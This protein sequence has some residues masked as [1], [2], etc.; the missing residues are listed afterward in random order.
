MKILAFSDIHGAHQRVFE[1]A[2][3]E[4]PFDAMI[5]AG[6]ITT[7]GTPRQAL[8]AIEQFQSLGKPLFVVT[9][10]MDPVDIGRRIQDHGSS[11]DGNGIV[12]NDVGFFGVGGSPFTPMHTPNELPEEEITRRCEEGWNKVNDARW[13]IF[14]PHAPPYKTTI[15]RIMTGN[16]VGSTAIRICIEQ[17]QP[18]AVVC[19]HIHEA[20]GTDRLGTSQMVNCG[21]AG[22]GSYAVIRI[23]DTLTIELRGGY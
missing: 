10:N 2:S 18:H 14:V 19:G 23:E 15:D 8:D 5:I 11:I 21:P 12:W 17:H 20:R 4:C 1:L 22:S 7:H 9:G 3:A 13:K 6:D 16:H